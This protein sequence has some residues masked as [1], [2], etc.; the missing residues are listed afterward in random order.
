MNK[1]FA[2]VFAACLVFAL[3]GCGGGAVPG[4]SA[5][6]E[7]AETSEWTQNTQVQEA[8]LSDAQQALFDE[9]VAGVSDVNY[10]PVGILGQQMVSGTNYAYLCKAIPTANQEVSEWEVAVIYVDP[11]ENA[12]FVC[13][14]P[15]NPANMVTT[16]TIIDGSADATDSADAS[17]D[18]A[19]ADDGQESSIYYDDVLGVYVDA[20]TGEYVDE[21]TVAE[22][23][24][25]EQPSDESGNPYE[26]YYY[27]ELVGAYIDPVTGEYIY[28]EASEGSDA[29]VGSWDVYAAYGGVAL[30][31]D[32]DIA[33]KNAMFKLSEGDNGYVLSPQALLATQVLEDGT[34]Y[35]VLC[36]GA[37]VE[38]SDAP[39]AVYNV[40]VF[41]GPDGSVQVTSMETVDLD[42]Y[43]TDHSA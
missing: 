24:A 23:E 15:I 11:E 22:I 9:A 28:P 16:G 41:Q 2:G 37:P 38:P 36:V 18:D 43:A 32:A 17:E 33:F 8:F 29:A 34:N 21:A 27:D 40:V 26:G 1:V 39:F 30:P 12:S 4:I 13:A 25:S 20:T 35:Q 3:A 10:E 42:Y 19:S 31:G 7:E 14:N 6:E 5:P